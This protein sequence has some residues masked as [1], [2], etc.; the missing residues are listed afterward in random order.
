MQMGA[1]L[2]GED[3]PD[4]GEAVYQGE[5]TNDPKTVKFNEEEYDDEYEDEGDGNSQTK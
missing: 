5:D 3:N 2:H 4:G 1:G